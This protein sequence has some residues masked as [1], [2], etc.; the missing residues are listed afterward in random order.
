M[1]VEITSQEA[2]EERRLWADFYEATM[3]AVEI[4]RSEG[5]DGNAVKRI[6]AEHAAASDAVARIKEIRGLR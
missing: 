5:T 2:A 6:V 4:I 1:R 3:R